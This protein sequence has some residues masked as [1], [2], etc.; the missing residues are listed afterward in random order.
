MKRH[1]TLWAGYEMRATQNSSRMYGG[2]IAGV[3]LNLCC[4]DIK[5][6][7][8]LIKQR[9]HLVKAKS[10]IR[11]NLS[12]KHELPGGTDSTQKMRIITTN[13][14]IFMKYFHPSTPESNT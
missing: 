2:T 5:R 13:P 7:I 8:I 10:Y 3:A 11:C 1:P 4:M 12:E 6:L 14:S 9:K